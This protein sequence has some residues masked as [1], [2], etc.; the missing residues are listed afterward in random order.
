MID[1]IGWRA[2]LGVLTLTMA[3]AMAMAMFTGRVSAQEHETARAPSAGRA[4]VTNDARPAS[5]DEERPAVPND[6]AAWAG[7]MLIIIIAMFLMAAVIG[8]MVRME[9]PV[10]SHDEDHGHG[11]D[12]HGHGH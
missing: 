10:E 3:M 7:T 1:R 9:M 6:A 4:S 5:A 2:G 12:D 8:P 11:H